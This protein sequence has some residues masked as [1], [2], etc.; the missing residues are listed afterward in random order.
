MGFPGTLHVHCRVPLAKRGPLILRGPVSA[1]GLLG[2]RGQQPKGHTG[3]FCVWPVSLPCRAWWHVSLS[4]RGREARDG[5]RDRGVGGQG[6]FDQWALPTLTGP[7][8]T[9]GSIRAVSPDRYRQAAV[10]EWSRAALRHL[11]G[12]FWQFSGFYTVYGSLTENKCFYLVMCRS[13]QP[14]Q[15]QGCP[16]LVAAVRAR[17]CRKGSGWVGTLTRHRPHPSP[18]FSVSDRSPYSLCTYRLPKILSK[19]LLQN[20]IMIFIDIGLL[21]KIVL[22]SRKCSVIL[23]IKIFCA[24]Q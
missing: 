24:S 7:R 12:T 8:F 23:I 3:L 14:Y 5:V 21:Y 20:V 4:P 19:K 15:G 22:A 10:K 18:G 6:V 13:S 2:C 17:C 9:E 11:P 16:G 1:E